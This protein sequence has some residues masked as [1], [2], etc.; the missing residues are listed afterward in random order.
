MNIKRWMMILGVC[1]ITTF[2]ACEN[3]EAG[4]AEEFAEQSEAYEEEDEVYQ[5]EEYVTD[6]AEESPVVDQEEDLTGDD[7]Q[8]D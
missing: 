3:Q 5:E 6:E 4:N 7:P 2:I 8:V 1:S